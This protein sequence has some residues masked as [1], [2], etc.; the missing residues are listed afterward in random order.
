MKKKLLIALIPL[1]VLMLISS[2]VVYAVDK[3]NEIKFADPTVEKAVREVL[4]KASGTIHKDD[5][6]VITW[7]IIHAN[8]LP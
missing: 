3:T 8:P 1:T 4:G 7:L 6:E 2:G 5:V